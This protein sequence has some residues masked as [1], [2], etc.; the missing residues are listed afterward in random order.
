MSK[1]EINQARGVPQKNNPLLTAVRIIIFIAFI[2]VISCTILYFVE[3]NSETKSYFTMHFALP[4]IL[5]M[6]G[7]IAVL[8][9]ILSIKSIQ[10]EN[11]G[12]N[13]MIVVG[14]LLI[15]CAIIS[16]VWSYI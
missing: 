13:F 4:C 1:K 9:A 16:L 2:V 6:V 10:G 14:I 7:L 11:K 8:M 12:D 3:F 15:L 5:F